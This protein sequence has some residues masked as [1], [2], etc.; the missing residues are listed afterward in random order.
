MKCIAV[1]ITIFF[2]ATG[3]AA[4]KI[5]TQRH[6]QQITKDED[7]EVIP[8]FISSSVIH[9]MKNGLFSDVSADENSQ[10]ER[11]RGKELYLP[12]KKKSTAIRH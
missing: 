8:S 4:A 2:A 9:S 10:S 7:I 6:P 5:G 12:P 11:F 3:P 1:I